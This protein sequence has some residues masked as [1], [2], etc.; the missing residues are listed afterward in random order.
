MFVHCPEQA[1]PLR[2][3]GRIL[4]A[5]RFVFVGATALV[6][7]GCKTPSPFGAMVADPGDPNAPVAAITHR[8]TM[9]TYVRRRPVEPRPWAEQNQG[10]APPSRPDR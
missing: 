3:G 1:R 4:R 2:H 6:I 8:S 9:D 7:S 10:V 5:L